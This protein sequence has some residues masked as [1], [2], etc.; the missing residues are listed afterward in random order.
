MILAA[1]D[2]LHPIYQ[3][4]NNYRDLLAEGIEGNPDEVNPEILHQRAWQI[5]QPL[6]EQERRDKLESLQ[7]AMDTDL[8]KCAITIENVLISADQGRVDTLFLVKDAQQWGQFD[9]TV[10]HVEFDSKP[11]IN[12]RDLLDLAA[13]RT[14][15]YGGK[16]YL[17]EANEMPAPGLAAALL[18]Y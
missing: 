14:L 15:R 1:V 3:K 9:P 4:A 5:V 2:Y 13:V 8:G 12:S 11:D 6:F 10:G 18:R 7:K 17:L 16:V